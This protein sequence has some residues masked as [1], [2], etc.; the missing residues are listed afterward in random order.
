[1]KKTA[2]IVL[3]AL[4]GLWSSASAAIFT[5]TVTDSADGKAI[6]NVY[7]NCGA[8][9][10][11]TDSLGKFVLNTTAGVAQSPLLQEKPKVT[12]NPA[13]ATFSWKGYPGEVTIR[14]VNIRGVTVARYT[15]GK[16]DGAS[17]YTLPR[18]VQEM[19]VVAVRAGGVTAFYKILKVKAH[20]AGQFQSMPLINDALAASLATAGSDTVK[21]T[22]AYY[23]AAVK[24]VSGSQSGLQVTMA[25]DSTKAGVSAGVTDSSGR[26]VLRLAGQPI[27]FHFTNVYGMPALGIRAGVQLNPD[28]PGM[29]VLLATF[30]DDAR[31]PIV[32]VLRG[33]QGSLTKKTGAPNADS[34]DWA[35]ITV[36]I[37]SF[38]NSVLE[39]LNVKVIPYVPGAKS[40]L[41]GIDI[42]GQLGDMAKVMNAIPGQPV[43]AALTEMGIGQAT[44][45]TAADALKEILNDNIVNSVTS[46]VLGGAATALENPTALKGVKVG[47]GL[48]IAGT[49]FDA[50][51]VLSCQGNISRLKTGPYVFY[52]CAQRP[53][54]WE[55]LSN[56]ALIRVAVA[57]SADGEG[58]VELISKD[59][60]GFGITA[61]L[62]TNGTAD[63]PVPLGRYDMHVE[64]PSFL[65]VL[66][67]GVNITAVGGPINVTTVPIPIDQ[68]GPFDGNWSGK[69]LGQFTRPDSTWQYD[70]GTV[71]ISIEDNV[72]MPGH[73]SV[74][75][76]GNG[77]WAAPGGTAGYTWCYTYTGTF[78]TSGSASGTWTF[79][80]PWSSTTGAGTWTATRQ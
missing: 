52:S 42:A 36:K 51:T 54:P 56:N 34:V 74:D 79:S 6:S 9:T 67:N 14:V 65:P 71:F 5:G 21:F 27:V 53:N 59:R 31:P 29:G 57:G 33:T 44:T 28:V 77:T 22:K 49:L 20:S 60:A 76:S 69:R 50:G 58:G 32:A 30:P 45:I 43:S 64:G 80:E 7:V 66:L 18:L 75:A 8:V 41:V 73:G 17:H 78:L 4:L 61:S 37:G 72:I 38:A 40:F 48:S 24:I 19:Y 26:V 70:G 63:I 10:V 35:G 39:I 15:A 11:I 12:W 16:H 1:M 3:A 62:N 47:M 2:A 68:S 23:R 25:Q 46:I 13:Q 55:D